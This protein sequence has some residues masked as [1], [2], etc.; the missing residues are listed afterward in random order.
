MFGDSVTPD[1]DYGLWWSYIP[2]FIDSP[3]YVYAYAFGEL[4]VLALY[5]RYQQVGAEFAEQYLGMLSA[6]G[7]DW[8]YEIVR[9][10]RGSAGPEL[11]AGRP[12]DPGR[13]GRPGG[14]VG[15]HKPQ[16]AEYAARLTSKTPGFAIRASCS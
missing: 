8:P 14:K 5:A 13:H 3:G 4:L 10:W 1:R 7:S 16:T 11:L 9:R 12:A 6:G 2:H 15:E